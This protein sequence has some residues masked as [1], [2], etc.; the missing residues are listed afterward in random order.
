[1][2]LQTTLQ[3]NNSHTAILFFTR[4]AEK[5]AEV[6]NFSLKR[7][8]SLNKKVAQ[9]LIN[10]TLELVRETKLPY[11]IVDEKSQNG[12][13]FGEKLSNAIQ[14]YFIKG[15]EHLIIIG[16][17]CLGLKSEHILKASRNLQNN[18]TVAGATING[19]LYLIGINKSSF[20]KSSFEKIRWQTENVFNDFK[21]LNNTTFLP[22]LADAN[23][24]QELKQQ[25]SLLRK[26]NNLLIVLQSYFASL[27]SSY[28][29][30]IKHF[31][32]VPLLCFDLR[33]PPSFS[34]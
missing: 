25:L 16:N 31:K 30:E 20:D 1:M 26:D 4:S 17:D 3:L 28:F 15:F 22:A 29:S 12:S 13:S 27:Q 14:E 8:I 23:N 10:K 32:Q 7:N 2:L 19:G 24:E 34:L 9:G 21:N 11:F 5:E 18:E 33:G 6:K